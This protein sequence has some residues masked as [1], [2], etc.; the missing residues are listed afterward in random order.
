MLEGIACGLKPTDKRVPVLLAAAASHR[1]TAL[2]VITEN[3][4]KAVTGWVRSQRI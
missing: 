3:T 4:T 1:A 2:P